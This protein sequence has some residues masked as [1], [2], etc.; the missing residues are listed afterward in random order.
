M[1]WVSRQ[2]HLDESGIVCSQSKIR[3]PNFWSEIRQI[4]KCSDKFIQDEQE[5]PPTR[6]L[7]SPLSPSPDPFLERLGTFKVNTLHQPNNLHW[8]VTQ[9]SSVTRVL[10]CAM[11]VNG[12]GKYW[13][14]AMN[15]WMWDVGRPTCNIRHPTS[16]VSQRGL[17]YG[18]ETS[19][20]EA[21]VWAP[22]PRHFSSA[23]LFKYPWTY[24]LPGWT[25]PDKV[26]WTKK[27]L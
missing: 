13:F 1:F 18:T 17:R 23:H 27:P 14:D 8:F 21:R 19:P 11:Q 7:I 26:N 15:I 3:T 12:S 4:Q 10:S 2:R 20:K 6:N 9:P 22:K 16:N 5:A 25:T 24:S